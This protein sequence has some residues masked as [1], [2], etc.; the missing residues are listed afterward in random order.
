MN[1]KVKFWS[2]VLALLLAVVSVA[3]C[4]GLWK[5]EPII[6]LLVSGFFLM[7]VLVGEMNDE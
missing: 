2:Q 5:L 6:L 3:L 7:G 4:V 1:S